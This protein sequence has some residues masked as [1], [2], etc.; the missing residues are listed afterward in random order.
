MLFNAVSVPPRIN[1]ESDY[2]CLIMHK[3][4][5]STS[6]AALNLLISR[7]PATVKK[8]KPSQ[9]PN[10]LPCH[11]HNVELFTG[12]NVSR[13]ETYESEV[14]E[15]EHM[16]TCVSKSLFSSNLSSKMGFS[17]SSRLGNF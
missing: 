14:L 5:H 7:V 17:F 4:S 16:L 13:D 10:L 3:G 9:N 12:G 15:S 2:S 1:L 8:E 6:W 11:G